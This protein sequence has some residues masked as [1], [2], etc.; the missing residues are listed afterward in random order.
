VCCKGYKSC[1]GI[2]SY[3]KKAC[4]ER[5]NAACTRAAYFNSYNY[6]TIKNILDK[7][8]DKIA[9]DIVEPNKVS[10]HDNIRGSQ[11]YK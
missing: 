11:Y 10:T 4:N 3:G 1:I 5:L 2:L 7:G 8:L 9:I 6:I